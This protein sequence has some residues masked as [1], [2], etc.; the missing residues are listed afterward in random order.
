MPVPKRLCNNRSKPLPRISLVICTYNREDI[1]PRC[2]VAAD[3]QSL[4][5]EDYEIIVVDN[6]SSDHT[7]DI[8]QR[9]PGV[10]YLYCG[11]RGL[12]SARNTGLT[13]ARSDLV[14][15]ID[16][17][18][19]AGRELLRELLNT[20]EANPDAGCVGGRIELIL[21]PKLP[22][23]YSKEFAGY[24]SAFDLGGGQPRRVS[25]MWEYPFGA[26][27]AYRKHAILE[28]GYFSEKLGRVGRNQS[29]GEELDL[30]CRIAALD[31]GIYYNPRARVEHVIMPQRL[32]WSHIANS[33]RAA[34]RN[35]AY[36]EVELWKKP[37]PMRGDVRLFVGALARL[38]HRDGFHLAYSQSLFYAAK[39]SRKLRY[40]IAG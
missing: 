38:G 13:A 9:Y 10:R 8:V 25:E 6:A 34:G 5:K 2:L 28:A 29:G 21:P 11:T 24:Y 32:R 12:S 37:A 40:R 14:A 31:Y 15:F 23:W 19:I 22:A 33:A 20:F 18:A 30:E 39:I 36:Y 3:S 1:L 4:A 26:N 27:V 17:D 35:W 7:R 16:D